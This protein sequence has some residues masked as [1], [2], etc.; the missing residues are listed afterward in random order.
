MNTDVFISYSSKD[1]NKAI[2]V[3]TYL[4]LA[5]LRC[6]IA[7]RDVVPGFNYAEGIVSSIKNS[8]LFLLV[9]T[10]ESSISRHVANEVDCAFTNNIPIVT[11]KI[12]SFIVSDALGYYLNRLHWLNAGE[13]YSSSFDVLLLNCK[14]LLGVIEKTKWDCY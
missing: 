4:E 6:W 2:E 5:K 11:F 9:L 14:R 13:N 7:P 12:G 3:C 10:S 8:K 1:S